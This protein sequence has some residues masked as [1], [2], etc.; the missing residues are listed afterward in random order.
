MLNKTIWLVIIYHVSKSI[1]FFYSFR[2]V[3]S[4]LLSTLSVVE[5]AVAVVQ[6]LHP[7]LFQLRSLS[8]LDVSHN[9]LSS[10][11]GI[12]RL[13]NLRHLNASN[14][15]LQ[16]LQDD[17]TSLYLLQQLDVSFNRISQLP[18]NFDLLRGLRHLD[19]SHNRITE[20]PN[21][22]LDVLGSVQVWP[23]RRFKTL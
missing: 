2:C 8:Y 11:E 10:L 21:D 20:L 12:A 19:L 22:R 18:L 3:L 15:R 9:R 4:C 1:T 23:A 6:E 14:N 13:Q 17:V 5:Y 7:G 16:E